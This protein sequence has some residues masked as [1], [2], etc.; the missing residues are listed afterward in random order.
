MVM[1][2]MRMMMMMMMVMVLLMM[3]MVVVVVVVVVEEVRLENVRLI[4]GFSHLIIYDYSHCQY[5]YH[6]RQGVANIVFLD[7]LISEYIHRVSNQTNEY[8]NI[9]ESSKWIE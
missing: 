6:M 8:P 2:M 7:K 3:M 1:M 4:I 5:L 9:F